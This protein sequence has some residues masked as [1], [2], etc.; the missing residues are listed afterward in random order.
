M[1]F[2]DLGGIGGVIEE[3]KDAILPFCQPE[4]FHH[5]GVKTMKPAVGIILHGQSRCGKTSLA[6][7]IAYEIGKPLHKVDASDLVSVVSGIILLMP[8]SRIRI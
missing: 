8:F 7:A 6:H 1:L 3:L 4:L 5:L 2:K